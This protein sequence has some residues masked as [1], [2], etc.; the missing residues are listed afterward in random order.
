[1]ETLTLP[2][3]EVRACRTGGEVVRYYASLRYPEDGQVKTV[4]M[5]ALQITELMLD[6]HILLNSHKRERA[7][8]ILRSALCDALYPTRDQRFTCRDQADAFKFLEG[9]ICDQLCELLKLD[10]QWVLSIVRRLTNV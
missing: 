7:W 5:T 9:E 3:T 6:R 4:M 2:M 10:H 1:M 8:A